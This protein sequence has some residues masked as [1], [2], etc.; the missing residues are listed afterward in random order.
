MNNRNE[1]LRYIEEND[2][3]FIKLTFCDIRGKLKNISVLSSELERVFENGLKITAKKI[4]GFDIT[5]SR[6]IFLH[7]D[8]TTMIPLPWRPQQGRVIRMFCF[9]NY[10][11]GTP[12][13]AD[14]RYLLK[15]TVKDAA[16][17]GYFFQFGTSCEFTLFR[18]D[19]NGRPTLT[20]HDFAGYCDTAPDDMGENIRRDI[21]LTLEQMN[22]RPLSSYHESGFG[23]HEID[24]SSY[25]ALKAADTFM[26][27]KSTVKSVTD[28]NNVYASFMPKP[29]K[30]SAGNGMHISI[31]PE[32]DF[33]TESSEKPACL[34]AYAAAGIMKFLKDMT[35]FTNSTCNS[36]KRLS[37]FDTPRTISWSKA[38]SS[39]IIRITDCEHPVSIRLA[40]CACNPY[41]VFA[42]MINAAV[43][44]IEN[45]LELPAEEDSSADLIPSDLDK[46]ADAAKDSEFLKKH[47]PEKILSTVISEKYKEWKEYSESDNKEKYELEH[48]FFCM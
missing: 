27:F 39:Q 9:I 41:Y 33:F 4:Y 47:M 46:A 14:S 43:Y 19:E 11:D 5:D 13:E 10:S 6:D 25:P 23:Q 17:K 38:D 15:K 34:S 3:K 26:S 37:S 31:I 48:Y 2:V 36:Y 24:F 28:R 35:L 29:L 44:G 42:L 45:R 7:P 12:F 8:C 20:P 21:C 40:D 22:I 32:K 16:D 1:I 30:N 18:N